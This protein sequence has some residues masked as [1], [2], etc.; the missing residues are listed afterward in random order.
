MNSFSRRSFLG[1][2]GGL[3]LPAW[4]PRVA[5]SAERAASSRRDT[6]ISIFQRGGNDGLNMVVPVG[7]SDYYRVRPTLAIAQP[8]GATGAAVDLDGFFGLHPALAPLKEIYDDRA[9]AVVHAVGSP[10]DT[11]SHFDAM[12]YLE[13]G[14]PGSKT[15][16]TGWLGRHLQTLDTGNDSPFRAVGMGTLVQAALRG[17][18]PATALQ[19]IADYHLGGDR[20]NPELARFEASLAA[21]YNDGGLLDIQS[22]ETFE[23]I[24]LLAQANPASHQPENGAVYPDSDFGLA[25]K[26]VAQLIRSEVGLEVAC[27]DIGGWDTHS[28]QG[29]ATGQQATLLA[30]FAAG[31]AAFYTDMGSRMAHITVVTM[32]EFGRRVA[33]NASAGTDHGHGGAMF[34]LGG[35]VNGGHVYGRWPGLAPGVLYGPGDLAVTTDFRTV[36]AELIEK[37]LLNPHLADVFPGFTNP[38][39]LGLVQAA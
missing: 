19:S 23:S 7:D 12:D 36:Q 2:L 9:L 39:Y 37:R 20:A 24:R 15:I 5:F 14:T 1:A 28:A 25:M 31:L 30:D 34:V 8:G 26:Q 11:H 21:L 33:E 4:F 38:G 3:S 13:R 29:A 10:D 18:I 35:A 16:G 32:S 22:A 6:L 17:P 27:V